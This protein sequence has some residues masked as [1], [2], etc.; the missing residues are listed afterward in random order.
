MDFYSIS[1][2][3]STCLMR[4]NI[5]EC[6]LLSCSLLSNPFFRQTFR[7]GV[8]LIN[9]KISPKEEINL[10]VSESEKVVECEMKYPY[11]FLFLP[12]KGMWR[13][14]TVFYVPTVSVLE[15]MAS[16]SSPLECKKKQD[17]CVLSGTRDVKSGV[18]VTKQSQKRRVGKNL[19][20]GF[21]SCGK[22][23]SWSTAS[24]S[25]I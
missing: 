8:P 23:L 17:L 24:T 18:R 21:M 19:R 6:N 4:D 20:V 7:G 14:C 9:L 13:V 22:S 16:F 1:V 2:W 25:T 12:A 3:T 11:F 10:T 5:L 15:E